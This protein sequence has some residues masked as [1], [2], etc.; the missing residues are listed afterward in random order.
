[1]EFAVT[2]THHAP[3]AL[4]S[5]TFSDKYSLKKK[6]QQTKMCTYR[7]HHN[8]IIIFCIIWGFRSHSLYDTFPVLSLA[9]PL[10]LIL[11]AGRSSNCKLQRRQSRVPHGRCP[12]LSQSAAGARAEN[13]ARIH[14]RR[15]T[16]GMGRGGRGGPVQASE[17]GVGHAGA[18]SGDG[19]SDRRVRA[20]GK[21]SSTR[22]VCRNVHTHVPRRRGHFSLMLTYF[23]YDDKLCFAP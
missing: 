7:F 11:P 15:G 8:L 2:I 16:C 20:A 22:T 12:H 23:S 5:L 17:P 3:Y 1:M 21:A 19:R 9:D 14:H 18:E 10:L 13:S 6:T 4:K